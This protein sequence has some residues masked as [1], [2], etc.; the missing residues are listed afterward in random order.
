MRSEMNV[1]QSKRTAIFVEPLTDRALIK[2][3]AAYCRCELKTS[4]VRKYCPR[5]TAGKIH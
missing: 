3:A 4:S 5:W 2:N 1:S